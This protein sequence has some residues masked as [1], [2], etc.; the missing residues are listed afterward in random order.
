[1]EERKLIKL[2]K[3][4][5]VISL[6][7]SWL[8]QRKL[9]AGEKVYLDFVKDGSLSVR[10]S[11]SESA[12]AVSIKV[13]ESLSQ[14]S[15]EKLIIAAYLNGADRITIE[16]QKFTKRQVETMHKMVSNLMGME[17]IDE[18]SN[19]AMMQCFLAEDL[20]VDRILPRMRA[21]IRSFF[22]DLAAAF[23]KR[24][25]ELLRS[26]P[27]RDWGVNKL[28]HFAKRQLYKMLVSPKDMTLREII[29]YIGL[30]DKYEKIADY[31]KKI[32]I[33][34]DKSGALKSMSQKEL[35]PMFG[36]LGEV[37]SNFEKVSLAIAKSDVSE[38]YPRA[39]RLDGLGEKLSSELDRL[40]VGSGGKNE[41]FKGAFFEST[42]R[43]RGYSR[44]ITDETI[45]IL[46]AGKPEAG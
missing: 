16:S 42:D 39:D 12:P 32:A 43:I 5:T 17:L 26:I 11:S 46:L 2:G 28:H 8:V 24:D 22:T 19:Q 34:A 29:F 21:M 30:V 4:S 41:V 20:P 33:A 44:L 3:T 9:K 6:P 14:V 27:E 23:A 25:V 13:D 15:M 35:A 36:I 31:L 38:L 40:I 18:S 1:M 37:L 10:S 7:T 45:D